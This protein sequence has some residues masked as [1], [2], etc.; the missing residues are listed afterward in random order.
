MR[1]LW[2]SGPMRPPRSLRDVFSRTL[3]VFPLLTDGGN[4]C[5]ACNVAGPISGKRVDSCAAM[6]VNGSPAVSCQVQAL[7][8]TE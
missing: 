3:V 6:T 2:S 8:V 5:T 4:D 1:W 7:C